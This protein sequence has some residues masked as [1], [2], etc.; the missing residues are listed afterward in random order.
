MSFLKNLSLVVL[1]ILLTMIIIDLTAF[2]ILDL[3]PIGYGYSHF[4]QFSPLT[5]HMHKPGAHGDWYRYYDGSKYEVTIN[6]FGFSDSPRELNKTRPRIALIGDS[7]TEFWEAEEQDRGQYVLEKLLDNKF[8]VLNF[9]VRGFGTDQSLIL[10]QELGQQFHPDIVVY[11]FCINDIYDN[12][13]KIN[14]PYYTL[15]PDHADELELKNFP[16]EKLTPIPIK[17]SEYL[18]YSYTYR[19]LYHFYKVKFAPP[20]P[21]DE[22]FEIRPYKKYYNTE[23]QYRLKLTL[24]LI[25]KLQKT[26][27]QKK[28][29]FILVEGLFIY[30]VDP[31]AKAEMIGRYGD[32]FDFGQ[33]TEILKDY[34]HHHKIPFLSL[35]EV[36]IK[37]GL[38]AK[39]FTH[40]EDYI[41]LNKAGIKLYTQNL[42]ALIKN[43]DK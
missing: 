20:L 9:G 6:R 22:Q 37:D 36:I 39:D 1:S 18:K 43:T 24:K 27:E 33:V 31:D 34:A 25:E 14:K 15:N 12:A 26:V 3:K 28:M 19:K 11:T 10:L 41:H 2:F 17:F 13:Q 40:S 35:N 16:L 7:T 21:L 38:K 42:A 29:K 30:A 8:E 23:D 32:I 4:F 5:G